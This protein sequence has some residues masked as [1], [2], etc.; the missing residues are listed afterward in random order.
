MGT[1]KNPACKEILTSIAFFFATPL[2]L[3]YFVLGTPIV[4]WSRCRASRYADNLEKKGAI[5]NWNQIEVELPKQHSFLI[6]RRGVGNYPETWWTQNDVLNQFEQQEQIVLEPLAA[7]KSRR[8]KKWL[9]SQIEKS[10]SVAIYRTYF[11]IYF[12]MTNADVQKL[13]DRY[14]NC[15]ITIVD[16]LA[17]F[18]ISDVTEPEV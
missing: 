17:W 16:A 10:P 1:S 12:P 9:A 7:W 11:D 13:L 18:P 6:F 5:R 4:W 2:L 15:Q 14:P 8:F 3:S